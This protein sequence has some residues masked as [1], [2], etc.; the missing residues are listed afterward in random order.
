MYK[1]YEEKKSKIR[2]KQ[3][4]KTQRKQEVITKANE[5]LLKKRNKNKPTTT[6][7]TAAGSAYNNNI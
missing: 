6:I 3:H 2:I 5:M 1:I 4:P 7:A